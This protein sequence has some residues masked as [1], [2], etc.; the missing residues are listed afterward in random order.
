M[1]VWVS[2]DPA[3]PLF[4]PEFLGLADALGQVGLILGVVLYNTILRRW[5]YRSM[6]ELFEALLARKWHVIGML[7]NAVNF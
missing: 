6:A 2:K 4:T 3:G 7:T 1:F 5:K